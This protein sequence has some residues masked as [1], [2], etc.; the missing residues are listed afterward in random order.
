VS[1]VP[2]QVN[3]QLS[4][5]QLLQALLI[6]SGDNIGDTLA[7]WAFGSTTNYLTQAN[8]FVARLGMQQTHLADSSGLS[9]QSVSSAQDLII[10]G[11]AVLQEPVLAAITSQSQV[12]LPLAGPVTNY[13]TLLGQNGVI[14]IKTGSTDQAGGCFLFAVTTDI[15]NKTFTTVGAILGAPSLG[16]VLQDVKTFIKN[17]SQAIQPTE[18]IKAGEVV[19][20]YHVPGQKP[21]EAIAQDDVWAF[22]TNGESVQV[23]TSLKPLRNLV[24]RGTVVGNVIVEGHGTTATSPVVLQQ[25]LPKVSLIWKLLHP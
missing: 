17:N 15:N 23:K 11:S 18:V 5:Y 6:P 12:T 4:E 14:G 16:A 25:T 24:S 7:N 3:E 21:V 10:L 19:G 2:I 20:T 13:N 1:A 22:A 8:Q 9:P